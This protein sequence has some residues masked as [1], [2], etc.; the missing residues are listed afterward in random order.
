[1]ETDEARDKR[2]D[3]AK[4]LAAVEAVSE[5]GMN[6]D[7][8]SVCARGVG[9]LLDLAE[10]RWCVEPPADPAELARFLSCAGTGG[11]LL[12]RA[13]TAEERVALAPILRQTSRVLAVAGNYAELDQLV[14]YEMQTSVEREEAMR[15]VLDSMQEGLVVCRPD[16]SLTNVLSKA[17]VEWFGP[18]RDAPVWSYLGDSD[19]SFALRFEIG[20]FQ[21]VEDILPFEL[22]ASQMPQY[23]TCGDRTFG[24]TYRQVQGGDG[25]VLVCIRDATAE[26]KAQRADREA[27]ELATTVEH[28]LED[29]EGFVAFV[30]DMDRML[31]LLAEPSLGP[32]TARASFARV[33]HTLKGNAATY[34]FHQFA[35]QCHDLESR[36]AEDPT[37]VD[38]AA[39]AALAADW[40]RSLAR[41][42]PFLEDDT[43]DLRVA[44]DELERLLAALRAEDVPT[45]ERLAA[46]WRGDLV[47][48]TLR[49]IARQAV[50]ISRRFDKPLETVVSANAS[51]LPH[52]RF[53]PLLGGLIHAVRNAIDHGLET[54]AERR[55]AGKP[56]VGRLELSCT[57]SPAGMSLAVR[58]DGR[59]IDWRRIAGK[60]SALGLPTATTADLVEAL[61][62]HGVSS[63]EEAGELSG[64]GV[65]MGALRDICR[66]LGGDV[67][68][69][70]A[71]GVGTTLVFTVPLPRE[72]NARG[73]VV[74]GVSGHV[75]SGHF[76]STAPPL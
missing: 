15:L 70:T 2:V 22:T 28:L 54:P 41:S 9:D 71:A 51:R 12:P 31:G 34:G 32:T 21:L 35:E 73:S 46:S 47:E 76:P 30:A 68:V 11:V 8:G 74:P 53:R 44:R 40:R 45:A 3:W 52:P 63:K 10:I 25:G 65:G 72:R 18:P 59:G 19:P 36:M 64:R 23:L 66:E 75:P 62:H 58:D 50:Q 33:L 17:A 60:A 61:F 13:P 39:I 24:F 42:R 55:V 4:V 43:R 49:S 5:C 16:G 29:R 67:A 56:E 20:F 14:Q 57:V 6:A 27:R 69:E 48:P 37:Q 38:L 1:M 26:F 7:V